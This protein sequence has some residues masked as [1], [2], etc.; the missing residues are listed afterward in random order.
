MW[1][2]HQEQ[3]LQCPPCCTFNYDKN[4]RMQRSTTSWKWTN[5]ETG[6]L[7]WA[8]RIRLVL[9]LV[10]PNMMLDGVAAW[11][12]YVSSGCVTIFCIILGCWL[13]FSGHKAA[14]AARKLPPSLLAFASGLLIGIAFFDIMPDAT[15]E[16][17]EHGWSTRGPHLLVIAG[18]LLVHFVD[19]VVITHSHG[20]TAAHDKH[21]HQEASSLMSANATGKAVCVS[22]EPCEPEPTATACDESLQP[23][24]LLLRLLAWFT[25]AF[26]D[27]IMVASADS[28]R[29][30]LAITLSVALCSLIDVG[31]LVHQLKGLGTSNRA[32]FGAVGTF[33][34]GFPVGALVTLQISMTGSVSVYV[35]RMLTAGIFI[36]MAIFEMAPPHTHGR[37]NNLV[38]FLPFVTGAMTA[39]FL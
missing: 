16:L 10:A 35:V 2:S 25:H 31:I 14:T 26:F 24:V 3:S 20:E 9:F 6:A 12:I 32:T 8:L 22:C 34:L 11:A 39:Y 28:V 21:H 1:A 36:Y 38:A 33:G 27:G 7:K 23:I 19:H 4:A 17:Q 5:R 37:V 18:G 13:I 15:L 30:L 29:S